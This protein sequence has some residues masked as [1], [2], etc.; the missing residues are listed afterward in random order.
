LRGVSATKSNDSKIFLT[1][2]WRYLAMLNYEVDPAVLAH[3]V[4][5]GTELDFWNGKTYVSVVGFLFRNARI[6][7]ISIPFH[8]NFEEVNLWFYVCRKADEGWRRGVV[9]IKELVPRKAIAFIAR[10][11]YNE[12]YIALPMS[13]R[14]EKIQEEIKSVSYGWQFN[15]QEN[16]LKMMTRGTAQPVVDN[17]FHEFITEHYWGYV[18][19]RDGS[20]MEYAVEHPRW[21]VWETEAAEFHCDV[22]NLYGKTFCEFLNR[23]PSS[24]FL[25]DGA[26]VKVYKGVRL[27]K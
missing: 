23:S 21:H 13:H 10:K 8:R 15:G 5:A 3:F 24:A 16:F 1:A 22:A 25:A 26:E 9:F 7:G 18:A 6:G 17:S 14:V 4:P 11:F 27:K 19:Q 2:E 20:A 12:N